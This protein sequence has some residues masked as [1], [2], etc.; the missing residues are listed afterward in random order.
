M[1][2]A[3]NISIRYNNKKAVILEKLIN[4][5]ERYRNLL[6]IS[7]VFIAVFTLLH[8]NLESLLLSYE[9]TLFVLLSL[10]AYFT[11]KLIIEWLKTGESFVKL[12][13][14]FLIGEGVASALSIN[15][16]YMVYRRS[17]DESSKTYLPKVPFAV[18]SAFKYIPISLFILLTTGLSAYFL[19]DNPVKSF[20]FIVLLLPFIIHLLAL[21][22]YFL[23]IN[24]DY[25][26]AKQ[27]IL[28]EQDKNHLLSTIGMKLAN[29]SL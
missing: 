5:F 26:Q 7:S 9:N 21:G 17:D 3:L 20:W 19:L 16:E 8:I 10:N 4:R 24:Q 27:K 2:V 28:D 11:L 22:L 18:K 6:I 25:I 29:K 15:I 14:R 23:F 13:V 12:F 1:P